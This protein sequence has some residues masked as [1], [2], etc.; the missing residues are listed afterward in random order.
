MPHNMF[1]ISS[2]SDEIVAHE[3]EILNRFLDEAVNYVNIPEH[4]PSLM[5][6][7]HTI[8]NAFEDGFFNLVSKKNNPIFTFSEI[9]EMFF[10]DHFFR[11]FWMGYY[12]ANKGFKP[13]KCT[14]CEICK[15]VGG[16]SN[17]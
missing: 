14:G 11:A 16:E 8:Q 7:S 13:S 9:A 4:H 17:G 6:V 2:V 1:N 3:F 12:A 5:L 15:K 10:G